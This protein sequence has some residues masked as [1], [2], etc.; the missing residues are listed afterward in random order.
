M[1]E[2][3]LQKSSEVAVDNIQTLAVL[4]IGKVIGEMD[5]ITM[6]LVEEA[7]RRHLGLP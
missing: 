3:G 1:P 7:L 2:N 5:R 6:E 4:K